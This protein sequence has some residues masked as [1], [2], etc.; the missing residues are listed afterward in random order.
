MKI[1]TTITRY[2]LAI[3]LIVFG[4]NK[5]LQFMPMPPLPESA[6]AFMAALA[7]SGYIMPIVAFVEIGAGVLLMINKFKPLALIV[8]FPIALNAFLFHAFLDLPGIGGAALL[9][10][11]NVFLMFSEKDAYASMLKA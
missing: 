4:L 5:F 8:L 10:I 9:I 11:M 1:A 3:M 6:G 7:A 2:L